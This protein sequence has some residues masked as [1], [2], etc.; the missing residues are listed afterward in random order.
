M[1]RGAE[2][3]GGASLRSAGCRLVDRRAAPKGRFTRK[4]RAMTRR[5][6]YTIMNSLIALW[7][8]AAAVVVVVHRFVPAGGWLM[9][10]LLLLGAVSTAILV[11]SQHFA[12]T[13]LRRTAWGGRRF[14]GVR[15]AAHTLGAATV[16][17]GIVTATW[18]VV[19]AGGI[20]LG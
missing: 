15:L 11:W 5:A 17:T 6:W 8:V 12:D 7:M 10:H 18:P 20:L 14:H 9:L 19:L 16:V 13:L 4:G 3:R 1:G 2:R